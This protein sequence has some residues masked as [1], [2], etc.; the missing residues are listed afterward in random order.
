MMEQLPNE[1]ILMILNKVDSLDD[2]LK[3]RLVCRRWNEL[4]KLI[5]IQTLQVGKFFPSSAVNVQMDLFSIDLNPVLLEANIIDFLK[6]TLIKT[7]ILSTI[8]SRLKQVC[9]CYV[10]IETEPAWISFEKSLQQLR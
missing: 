10:H 5:R 9:F 8:L 2:I 1:L 6:S 4:V 3:C 7:T